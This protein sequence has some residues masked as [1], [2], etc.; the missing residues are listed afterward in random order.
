MYIRITRAR[1][2]PARTEDLVAV[3]PD[4]VATFRRLPGFQGYH[5]GVD[6]ARGTSVAISFWDTEEHAQVPR[7]ALAEIIRR[8]EAAS[9]QLEPSEFYE[10]TIRA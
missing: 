5:V 10:E 2:D 3:G 1:F 6:R 4:L 8:L 7:D 9:L